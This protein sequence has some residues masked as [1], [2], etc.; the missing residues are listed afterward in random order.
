MQATTQTPFAPQASKDGLLSDDGGVFQWQT[1]RIANQAHKTFLIAVALALISFLIWASLVKLDS[2]TRGEGSIVPSQNNQIVQHLEGGIVRA[3]P[4]REGQRVETGDVLIVVEDQFAEAELDTTRLDLAALRVR[5]GRLNAESQGLDQFSVDLEQNP[6]LASLIEAERVLFNRR[7]QSL[8]ER[9][10]ILEDQMR[11]RELELGELKL[12]LENTRKEQNLASERVAS[13]RRLTQMGAVSKNELLK[14]ETALQQINTRIDDLEFQIPQTEAGLSEVVRR[15]NE[16][17]LVFRS[18]SE[19]ERSDVELEIA[20]LVERSNALLDRKVRSEVRSP[21][22]GIVNR[23]NV[24]TVGGV[25]RP[26]QIVAEIVPSNTAI[27]VEARLSPKDRADVW[28]G[29]PAI[30]KITAYDYSIYG[31]IKGKVID[32]SPDALKGD[33]GEPYFRVRLEADASELGAGNPVVPG[34][35][36]EVDILTSEHTILSYLLKPVSRMRDRALRQ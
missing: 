15:R 4:I 19:R 31:G 18:E 28:P 25:V 16:A 27:T 8:R 32:V 22:T 30:V 20:K 5:L 33:Q 3:I 36:A 11:Q 10:G 35:V 34:M 6:E 26:G 21:T 1:G 9:I 23:L 7:Q 17:I 13:L 24:K 14:N 2:V 12:R 29:L